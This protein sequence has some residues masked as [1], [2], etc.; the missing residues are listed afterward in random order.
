MHIFCVHVEPERLDVDDLLLLY[1][2]AIYYAMPSTLDNDLN[3]KSTTRDSKD[4]SVDPDTQKTIDSIKNVA[5]NIRD[6]SAR[7]RDTVRILRQ[8]GAI[9][10]LTQAVHEASVAAR[11]IT[12]EVNSAT[13]ELKENG[14]I[15]RT[16]SAIEDTTNAARE[17]VDVVRDVARQATESAPTTGETLKEAASKIKSKNQA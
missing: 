9:D 8:S 2:G 15:V 3:N 16:A 1:Y 12:R 7:V 10:E 6:A 17:T 4:V 13:K 5:K 14:V 11:D